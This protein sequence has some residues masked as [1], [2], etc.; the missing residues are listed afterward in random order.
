MHIDPIKTHAKNSDEFQ[1]RELLQEIGIELAF[2]VRDTDCRTFD[3]ILL[4]G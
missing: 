4:S 2:P 1:S 3:I